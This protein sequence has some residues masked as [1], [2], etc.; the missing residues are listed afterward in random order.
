MTRQHFTIE[1]FCNK[2]LH[3]SWTEKHN[4]EQDYCELSCR[5]IYLHL[6]IHGNKHHKIPVKGTHKNSPSCSF[7]LEAALRCNLCFHRI[8][9]IT[10]SLT[11]YNE[12]RKLVITTCRYSTVLSVSLHSMLLIQVGNIIMITDVTAVYSVAVE[13]YQCCMLCP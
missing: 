4:S 13:Q 12:D 1:P 5:L 7:E 11:S 2:V 8:N 9:W 6:K 10:I 3:R